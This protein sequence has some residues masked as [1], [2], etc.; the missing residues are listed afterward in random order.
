VFCNTLLQL[1][2]ILRIL[3][4]LRHSLLRVRLR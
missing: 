4:T 3:R 1:G 2:A